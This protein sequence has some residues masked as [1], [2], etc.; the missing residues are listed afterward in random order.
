MTEDECHNLYKR[1]SHLENIGNYDEA[2]ACLWQIIE[3]VQGN[4][5]AQGGYVCPACGQPSKVDPTIASVLD[6]NVLSA[7]QQEV[8]RRAEEWALDL[9]AT[10]RNQGP[11]PKSQK[12]YE[13]VRRLKA[14]SQEASHDR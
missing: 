8:L 2:E 11:F 12:L 14:L 5:Y 13:A 9:E 7:A 6:T 1:I 4:S 3:S 10:G